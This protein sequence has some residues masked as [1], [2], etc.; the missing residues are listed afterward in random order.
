[1]IGDGT[2]GDDQSFPIRASGDVVAF[3]DSTLQSVAK[4]WSI[5][6]GSKE[7][8]LTLSITRFSVNESNKA[9]GSIYAADV[10]LAFDLA[11]AKGHSLARGIGSGEAHRYGRA[12]SGDNCNEVLSD[13]LKDAFAGVLTD[14]ALQSAWMSG[15]ASGA[16]ATAAVAE[17]KESPEERLKKLESLYKK[18]VITKEEYDRKRTEILKEL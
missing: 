11:D 8:V 5:A 16:A 7:R 6:T 13:A 15:K 17:P 3:V 14:S 2:N 10:K 9:V 4:D 1:V 18:G 12:R